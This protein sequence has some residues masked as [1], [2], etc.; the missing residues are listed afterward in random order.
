[1]SSPQSPSC[2]LLPRWMPLLAIPASQRPP[3]SLHSWLTG[4][5]SLTA[6]LTELAEGHFDV[7]ILQQRLALPS[8][9]EQQQLAMAR[10]ALALVRE[11]ALRGGGTPW[12]F[13]R[14]VLPLSSLTGRLRR[15]RKQDSGSLGRFLF[16]HHDLQ[17]SPFQVACFAP[18]NHYVPPPLQGS[19]NLWGRRSVF[20]LD[21]KPLL[22]S[23]VFLDAFTALPDGRELT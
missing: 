21:H 10:P 20:Y 6:R 17:R 22:V 4:D 16:R 2:S 11:V 5:G 8:R 7:Q 23:E 19:N 9:D 18:G 14:S 1:M 12:V 15:L 3:V 13:A